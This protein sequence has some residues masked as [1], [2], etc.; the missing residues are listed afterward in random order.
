MVKAIQPHVGFNIV[1]N[2]E[3]FLKSKIF[4]IDSMITN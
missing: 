3:I 2:G 1:F 4:T